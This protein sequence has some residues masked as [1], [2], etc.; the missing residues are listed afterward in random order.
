MEIRT[1]DD[2]YHFLK[3]QAEASTTKKMYRGV[4]NSTFEL[5]PSIGRL[6]TIDGKNL[7]IGEEI[8]IFDNFRNRAYPFTR[9]H[10]YDELDLLSIAQH[11]G[12]PTRLLDWT[13]N[14]MVAMYFAVEEPFMDDGVTHTEFSCIY[15]H[16]AATGVKLCE[17]FN[18]FKIRGI[19]RYVHKYLDNRIIAQNG[20]FTVHNDPHAAWVPPEVKTVLIHKD[21]RR[22]IKRALNRL[23][24]NAAS[25]YP[26]I[27]GLAK[28]IT[29]SLSGLY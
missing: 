20:L 25:I 4:R 22:D 12:L 11:H 5:I 1:M 2:F 3:T 21:I 27:D 18:P 7:T 9:E 10:N 15:I 26:D 16:T 13:K 28:H 8:A 14:P 23:G 19:K 29:W 6:K 17:T 24:V